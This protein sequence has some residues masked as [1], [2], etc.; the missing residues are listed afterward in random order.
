MRREQRDGVLLY[1]FEGLAPYA[2]VDHAILTRVGGVSDPPFETLN[3]GHS[4][5]DAPEAVAENHRRA[6]GVLEVDPEDVVS[7]HQVHG[8]RVAPVGPE[9]RGRVVPETDALVTAAPG[10]PLMMRFADCAPVLLFDPAH[11]VIA[12]A[13]AGWRGTAAGVVGETVRTLQAH[14]GTDPGALWAGIGPAIGPCC[15][16]VGPEVITAIQAATPPGTE[17][18]APGDGSPHLDLP[19]AVAAQLRVAGVERVEESGLCTACRGDEF[20][21]HR[22]EDGSTGRFGVVIRIL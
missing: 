10:V 17:I 12:L 7:P 21:S 9:D 22:A 16:E 3:L 1:R 6:L 2:V 19:G 5:G 20:F 8:A 15:Y 4:V 13:H 14:F 18:V 11:H